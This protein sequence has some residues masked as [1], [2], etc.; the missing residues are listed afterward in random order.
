MS[1]IGQVNLD[2]QEQAEALGFESVQE[3]L[4]NGYRAF[5]NIDGTN[6]LV[7]VTPDAD[8][9]R[10]SVQE[11]L[12]AMKNAHQDYENRKKIIIDK[13]EMLIADTQYK[14]YKDTLR[15]V[16]DFLKEKEV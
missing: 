5:M 11:S 7:K 8:L 14:V 4:D 9:I 3:A 16:I 2:L 10:A 15:E 13:L 6:R 12:D 1:K